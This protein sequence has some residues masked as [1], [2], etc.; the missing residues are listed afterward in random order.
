M[1]RYASEQNL[2]PLF[3][4]FPPQI[5][6]TRRTKGRYNYYF[7]LN[8]ASE[9]VALKTEAGYFDLLEGRN[10]QAVFTLPPYGYKVLR[11]SE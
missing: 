2:K 7:I 3:A 5:E 10:A 4:G 6:V 9:S 1:R 8:H 11:K